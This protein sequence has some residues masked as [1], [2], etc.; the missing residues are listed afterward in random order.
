MTRENFSRLTISIQQIPYLFYL[1]KWIFLA[2][3]MSRKDER[4]TSVRLKTAI[5]K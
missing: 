2:A 3:V 5:K 1:F 4:K